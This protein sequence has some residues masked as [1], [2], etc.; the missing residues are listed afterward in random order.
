MVDFET[1]L[2]EEIK[3]AMRDVAPILES[4]AKN[5]HKFTSQT[6]VLQE[7]T[8]SEWNNTEMRIENYVPAHVDYAEYVINGSDSWVGDDY[9]A[10]AIEANQDVI[11][12]A[13]SIASDR[14]WD[15]YARQDS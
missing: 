9:I 14:A 10:E 6:G 5:N 13:I 3:I 8:Y 4:Y 15:R 7:N 11:D 12:N 2:N 1:L